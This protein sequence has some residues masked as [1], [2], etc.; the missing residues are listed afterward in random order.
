MVAIACS[1]QVKPFE[2]CVLFAIMVL[3]MQWLKFPVLTYRIRN[4]DALLIT[5]SHADAT[6]GEPPFKRLCASSATLQNTL[7][8]T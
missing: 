7:A 4:L 8:S 6:G 2:S 3:F 1:Y 5:H